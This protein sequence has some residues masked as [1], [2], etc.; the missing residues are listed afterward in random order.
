MTKPISLL[1]WSVDAVNQF[2][3]WLVLSSRKQQRPLFLTSLVMLV[4][5]CSRVN[6]LLWR[7]WNY[8]FRNAS[9]WF[10]YQSTLFFFIFHAGF[11]FVWCDIKGD[12]DINWRALWCLVRSHHVCYPCSWPWRFVSLSTFKRK[13]DWRVFWATVRYVFAWDSKMLLYKAVTKR[14][15]WW[16]QTRGA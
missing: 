11:I 14:I 8:K 9:W 2:K 1:L 13:Y 3:T 16:F 10:G 7:V 5:T 15:V 6:C 12:S 4:C